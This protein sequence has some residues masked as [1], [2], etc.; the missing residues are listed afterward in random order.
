MKLDEFYSGLRELS[1]L[2]ILRSLLRRHLTSTGAAMGDIEADVPV[3]VPVDLWHGCSR[4]FEMTL[5]AGAPG[6]AVT[7]DVI[8]DGDARREQLWLRINVRAVGHAARVVEGPQNDCQGK[9]YENLKRRIGW[10]YVLRQVRR[11]RCWESRHVLPAISVQ[12]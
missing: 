5:A 2:N 6:A 9:P 7:A 8:I 1:S 4:P 10:G 12:N 3:Q 11:S